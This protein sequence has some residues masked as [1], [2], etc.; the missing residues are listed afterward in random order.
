MPERPSI[1]VQ[2]IDRSDDSLTPL[3]C[4]PVPFPT[5]DEIATARSSTPDRL[6]RIL[7]GDLDA[8]LL[9]AL[10]KEPEG[11]YASADQFADDLKRYRQGLP[12]QAR[13]STPAYRLKKF[14]RRNVAATVAALLVVLSVMTGV[15]AITRELI[16]SRRDRDRAEQ[17]L[18]KARHAADQ[19]FNKIRHDRRL[20]QTGLQ[21]IR[22]ALFANLKPIYEDVLNQPDIGARTSTAGTAKVAEA[23][24]TPCQN[25]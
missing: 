20:N 13:R 2:R 14:A 18:A 21:P 23:T 12:V 25:Q 19:L 17:G 11:R 16:R 4:P 3:E 5:S 24:A 10:S 7:A 15:G 9:K 22:Q 8:I 6:E 1:A